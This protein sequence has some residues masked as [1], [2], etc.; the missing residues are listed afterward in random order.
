[1]PKD[2]IRIDELLLTLSFAADGDG[3]EEHSQAVLLSVIIA[4]DISKAAR[5]DNVAYSIDYAA[6]CATLTETLPK[7]RYTS[8]EA[9]VERVFKTLF[10]SHPDVDEAS[11]VVTL[12]DALP[13]VTIETTRR[14]G[15]TSTGPY[16]FVINKLTFSAI[17]G[18]NPRERIE[19]QPVVFDIT[20]DRGVTSQERFPFVALATSIHQTFTASAYL[21]VEAFASAVAWHVLKY[22][23]DPEDTVTIKL[24]KPN[25]L[26]FAASAQIQITRQR[27]DFADVF[28]GR[29]SEAEAEHSG[30]SSSFHSVALALGSNLGD[31]FA[32]IETALRL[33]EVPTSML[34]NLP[35][36]AQVSVVDTS[37]MYETAPMYVTDQP[38][39]ANCACMIETN[40]APMELL[41]LVKEIE[42]AVGRMP[43]MRFGPRA[44]DLD[45]L[46][47]DDRLVDTRPPDSRASLDNLI[48]ELVIPHPRMCEREFVLRSLHDMIPHYI[49]PSYNKTIRALLDELVSTQTESDFPMLKVMPFPKYP[50]ND[51]EGTKIHGIHVPPTAT[52]W[53]MSSNPAKHG[54]PRKTHLMAT[55][56]VTPDSFSDGAQHNTLPTALAYTTA[57][58]SSGADMIDIGGYST[59]P[60]A[61]T[62]STDEELARVLPVVQAI[63]AH[64]SPAV[65]DVLLS[66]DTFRWE[67]AARA[68]R[69]GVNCINDV[70]A[71]T[72]PAYPLDAASWEHLAR[73]RTVARELCVPV[74]L[75]H[76]RGDAGQNKGYDAYNNGGGIVAAVQTELGLK[77]DKIVRGPG[78]VRRWLVLVDPGI[79]FSK[80]VER[81]LALMR[82]LGRVTAPASAPASK[83]TLAHEPAQ[84]CERSGNPLAGYP[85]LVGPSKK[86][87]WGTVLEEGDIEGV[88]E[89]R[90]T[91]TQERGWATAAAVACA[92][93]Q[94]ASVVRVHDVAEMRDVVAVASAIWNP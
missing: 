54:R 76:S 3:N 46:M 20:I 15:Q 32:N 93:Q 56:N 82:S 13:H 90:K 83:P 65:R 24:S 29:G 11:V 59:R 79:G 51:I 10:R 26:T 43:S 63:R 77:V 23:R 61:A 22:T 78:G 71:F 50:L 57:A 94:G 70:Y 30:S 48:G 53:T 41:R 25:A 36:D 66:V 52:Y 75:M 16:R 67:V 35:E 88:Y 91:G 4:H 21:T 69:A 58:I 9:L 72:G 85:L 17:L 27:N 81:Q 12:Q 62:V 7:T 47:Y 31:R 60:G 5:S 42:T 74:V 1:M 64:P 34:S 92:V 49:H 6:V 8:L 39:F 14:R 40:L 55:L 89:G 18:V 73:M 87:V 44:V 33:L 37:F 84:E 68:V 45:I 2:T 19:K 80:P 38:R 28:A 86:S